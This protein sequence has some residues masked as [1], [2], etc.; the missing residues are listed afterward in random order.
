MNALTL[1]SYP[2]FFNDLIALFDDEGKIKQGA[3]A[4]LDALNE[5]L[6]RLKKRERKNHSPLRSL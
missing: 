4:T 3:N 5:S 6:N 1:L 2:L